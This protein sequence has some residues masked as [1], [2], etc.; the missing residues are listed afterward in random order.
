MTLSRACTGH[1]SLRK[2]SLPL[3]KGML[4]YLHSRK[5]CAQVGLQQLAVTHRLYAARGWL[6]VTRPVGRC[7]GPDKQQ[8]SVAVQVIVTYN[9]EAVLSEK[10]LTAHFGQ[11]ILVGYSRLI[12]AA[13]HA[14]PQ[15][16]FE[17]V[18]R[19]WDAEWQRVY[20]ADWSGEG[21]FLCGQLLC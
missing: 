14:E 19:V 6:C 12:D 1:R 2:S 10:Q 9:K 7:R 17:E 20:S 4:H 16:F 8:R 18:Q 21:R 13:D 3:K 11:T 5:M 15:G